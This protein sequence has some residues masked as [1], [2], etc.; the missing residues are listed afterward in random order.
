MLERALIYQKA[1]ERLEEEDNLNV[2]VGIREDEIGVDNENE[3]V[4]EGEVHGSSDIM[5]RGIGQGKG[6]GK[7]PTLGTPTSDDWNIVEMYVEILRLLYVVTEKFSVSLC[8]TCNTFFK[9]VMTIKIAIGKLEASE[10]VNLVLLA[11]GMNKKYDKYWGHF[12]KINPL[13]LYAN[14]LDPHYKFEYVSWSLGKY[15]EKREVESKIVETKDGM[16]RLYNW[17]EKRSMEDGQAPNVIESSRNKDK[18]GKRRLDLCEA[19]DSEFLQHMEEETNMVSKSELERD[20]AA[21]FDYSGF[22]LVVVAL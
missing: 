9:E 18:R 21:G 15:N 22:L 5:E 8:V 12:S 10:D 16:K 6:R 7:R 3:H 1:F 2:V 20:Y 17:Y 19:M 4:L 13:L 14:V 11:R